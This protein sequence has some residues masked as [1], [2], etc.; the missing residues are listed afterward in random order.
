MPTQLS[1]C[2]AH[3]FASARRKCY[4]QTDTLP[5]VEFKTLGNTLADKIGQ[6]PFFAVADTLA[7]VQ[8][9][10]LGDKSGRCES[11]GTTSRFG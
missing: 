8:A 5:D 9:E 2:I 7:E 4:G 10:T 6:A 1:M 11:R 3:D